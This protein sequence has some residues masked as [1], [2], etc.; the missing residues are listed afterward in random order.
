[1]ILDMTDRAT[2]AASIPHGGIVLEV[3]VQQGDYAAMILQYNEPKKLYLVDCWEQQSV[4]DYGHDPANVA[5]EEQ[6]SREQSTRERFKDDPRV[7]IIKSYSS[8]ALALFEDQFFDWIYLDANHLRLRADLEGWLPKLKVGGWM[9][10]HDYCVFDD[11]IMVK[12]VLDRFVKEIDV[13]L[14]VVTDEGFPSW[15]FK[16]KD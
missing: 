10:G 5:A 16:K 11:F 12:P 15:A 2:M 3:G 13:E 1:M 7:E 4:A 8:D 6:A 14:L 9:S